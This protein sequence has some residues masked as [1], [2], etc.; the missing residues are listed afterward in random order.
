MLLPGGKTPSPPHPIQTTLAAP[1]LIGDVPE[2]HY[3]SIVEPE[4]GAAGTTN[5]EARRSTLSASERRFD[6]LS[7]ALIRGPHWLK[8]WKSGTW[9]SGNLESKKTENTDY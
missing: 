4:T 2:V 3:G 5:W 6:K 1:P 9:T 7:K 8:I